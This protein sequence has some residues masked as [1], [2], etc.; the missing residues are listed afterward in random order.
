MR[1]VGNSVLMKLVVG[2][3]VKGEISFPS[4]SR[5]V[6]PFTEAKDSGRMLEL[7]RGLAALVVYFLTECIDM[8]P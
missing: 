8:G 3:K 6:L 4:L 2:R 5:K 1:K 7:D